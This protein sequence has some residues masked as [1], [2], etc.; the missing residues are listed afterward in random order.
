MKETIVSDLP[1]RAVVCA[2]YGLSDSELVDFADAPGGFTF[3]T[4]DGVRY[5]DVP[6]DA[7]DADG[8]TGL[9]YVV[10]PDVAGGYRGDF[11][12]YVNPPA[13]E[14][15]P[16]EVEPVEVEPAEEQPTEEQSA[17]VPAPAGRRGK[18]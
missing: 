15:A 4:R 14:P 6:A 18:S 7:P 10:A 2:E 16:V 11:P 12:V 17:E 3:D 13:E 1:S 8:K 9:M 5:I